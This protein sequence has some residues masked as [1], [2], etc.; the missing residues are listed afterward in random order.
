MST[1]LRRTVLGAALAGAAVGPPANT[2]HA[3]GVRR[4]LGGISDSQDTCLL[5]TDLR[6]HQLV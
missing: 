5:L 6:D 4:S 3:V 1:T 2:A